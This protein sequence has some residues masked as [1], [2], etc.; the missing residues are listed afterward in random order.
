MD[1]VRKVASSCHHL[2]GGKDFTLEACKAETYALGG[3]V[4]N[5]HQPSCYVKLCED[6]D[7]PK[8]TYDYGGWDVYALHRKY[9]CYVNVNDPLQSMFYVDN[10]LTLHL[11]H[12]V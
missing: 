3:N 12:G 11:S 1:G 9:R 2:G 4:F 8:W 10:H 5:Y 7:D 6:V